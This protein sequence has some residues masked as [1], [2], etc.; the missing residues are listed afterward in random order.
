LARLYRPV[1]WDRQAEHAP[2]DEKIARRPVFQYDGGMFMACVNEKLVETGAELAGE[3]L[4]AEAREALTAMRAIL[5]SPELAVQLTIEP[6]QVQL[7]NNR[8]FA[9]PR[10]DLTDAPQP[11]LKRH[12][13][14]LWTREE[15][16]RT[17][18]G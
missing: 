12:M 4:D 10:T 6:G 7:I 14:R 1:R 17:F 11:H 18:H 15:G 16:R 2:G 8:A 9:H 3:P 5:D 13:I